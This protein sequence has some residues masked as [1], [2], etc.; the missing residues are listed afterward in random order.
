M[1]DSK[2]AV[3]TFI[4]LQSCISLV[5]KIVLQLLN[6]DA[7]DSLGPE[8]SQLSSAR[9]SLWLPSRAVKKNT[10][11]LEFELSVLV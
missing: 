3:S 6:S 8:L 5:T 11:E 4:F 9:R 2:L 1:L 7:D 10:P